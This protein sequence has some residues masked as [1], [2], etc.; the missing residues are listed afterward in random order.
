VNAHDMGREIQ[1]SY[2][3]GPNFYNPPTA[4]Y[5]VRKQQ[6]FFSVVHVSLH[7]SRACLGKSSRVL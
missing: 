5:P 2:Y 1:L 6:R 4:K 3:S 7:L